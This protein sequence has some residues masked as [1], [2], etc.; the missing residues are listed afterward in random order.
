MITPCS[1]KVVIISIFPEKNA[2]TNA[3][4]VF[5]ALAWNGWRLSESRLI[6]L[7]RLTDTQAGKA[8]TEL[9]VF[10]PFGQTM[11]YELVRK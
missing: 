4:G 6:L 5:S 1:R 10:K 8:D 9:N 3:Y 7:S 11:L 2:M